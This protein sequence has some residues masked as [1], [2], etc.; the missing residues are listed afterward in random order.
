MLPLSVLKYLEVY[1]EK[2]YNEVN[3]L[4]WQNYY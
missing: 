1:Q 3:S 4:N 2:V